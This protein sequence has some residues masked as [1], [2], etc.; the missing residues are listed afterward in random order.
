MRM[1]TQKIKKKKEG[2]TT[3]SFVNAKDAVKGKDNNGVYKLLSDLV[4]T[5]GADRKMKLGVNQKATD[6]QI[7]E[8]KKGQGLWIMLINS[9]NV[10]E[11]SQCIVFGNAIRENVV[12]NN[13]L[14]FMEDRIKDGG[15]P[16]TQMMMLAAVKGF[17]MKMEQDLNLGQGQGGGNRNQGCGHDH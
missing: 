3:I 8:F 15:N 6:E 10:K 13:L 14:S 7:A 11:E 1:R 17:V 2:L 4:E 16:V 12:F 9:D 5:I